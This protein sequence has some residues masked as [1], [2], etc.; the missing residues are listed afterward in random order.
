M[1]GTAIHGHSLLLWCGCTLAASAFSG[2]L[3]WHS[4]AK[5]SYYISFFD[6]EVLK[7]SHKEVL[8]TSQNGL[9][10]TLHL[11][12]KIGALFSSVYFLHQLWER[13]KQSSSQEGK[14][15]FVTVNVVNVHACDF[16]KSIEKNS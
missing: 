11:A 4:H 12:L 1:E 3:G 8:A 9:G 7:A 6:P 5:W 14:K 16:K 2:Y 10:S 13:A 15:G